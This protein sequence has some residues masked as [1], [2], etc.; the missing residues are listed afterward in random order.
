MWEAFGAGS[1]CRLVSVCLL[2]SMVHATPQVLL[3][4]D[5][6]EVSDPYA[7]SLLGSSVYGNLANTPSD[8]DG[9]DTSASTTDADS[10]ATSAN[11]AM[12]TL[13]S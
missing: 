12:R 13:Q 11:T 9:P 2:L 4:G 1:V 6:L 7:E 10:P 5:A 8:V 3:L